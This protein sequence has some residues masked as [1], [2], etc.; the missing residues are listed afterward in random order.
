MPHTFRPLSSLSTYSDNPWLYA[1]ISAIAQEA[2]RV[3]MM[4]RQ[5]LPDGD[6]L[7]IEKHQALD[8]LAK[9]LPM[10]EAE[11]RTHMTG[12][13]L[14]YLVYLNLQLNGE[15]FWLA[16]GMNAGGNPTRLHTL[17]PGLMT[18]TLGSD[19]FISHYFY[20]P[21][22]NDIRFEAKEIVQMKMSNP[23][24]YFRGQS[25]MESARFAVQQQIQADLLNLGRLQNNAIPAGLLKTDQQVPDETRKR[26]VEQWKNMFGGNRSHHGHSF[27]FGRGGNLAEGSGAGK[28]GFLPQGVD[29]KIIQQNNQEMQ[30]TEMKKMSRE[31]VLANFRVPME[32][33][34]M[35]DNQT[36]A[37]AEASN[38]V[39]QRYTVLPILELVADSLTSDYLPMFDQTEDLEFFFDDPV[40]ENAEEKR[41]TSKVLF[42]IGSVTPNEIRQKFGLDKLDDDSADNTFLQ[43]NQVPI[44]SA[45]EEMSGHLDEE[46]EEDE[47]RK[48]KAE[49]RFERIRDITLKSLLKSFGHGVRLVSELNADDVLL[50]AEK[51]NLEARAMTVALGIA[52]GSPISIVSA[53][54]MTA[55]N[56]G[57][58]RACRMIGASPSSEEKKRIAK[59]SI[60]ILASL[61][62]RYAQALKKFL[63]T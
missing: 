3:N 31:E 39:F 51:K 11:G 32:V 13:E 35:T 24:N 1:A 26:L 40:P 49:A 25:P 5:K 30:F 42:G 44:A 48:G 33:L 16:N 59:Q 8:V 34:G 6:F 23:K 45:G 20:R 28:V 53:E 22:G 14:M 50:E 54:L 12:R 55:M 52:E 2:S 47:D 17:M 36:R 58:N 9:P 63:S 18:E 10:K 38:F 4:L 62:G 19:N 27:G 7:K 15:S 41:E 43:F 37:N 29:F 56:D 61:E 21:M 57:T 46:E 60:R